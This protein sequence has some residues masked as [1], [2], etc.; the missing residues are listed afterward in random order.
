MKKTKIFKSKKAKVHFGQIFVHFDFFNI[1]LK[2]IK[3]II[4]SGVS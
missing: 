3:N 2:K 1:F 4:G